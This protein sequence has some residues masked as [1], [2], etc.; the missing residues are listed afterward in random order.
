MT[1][2]REIGVCVRRRALCTAGVFLLA[3]FGLGGCLPVQE[4]KEAVRRDFLESALHQNALASLAYARSAQEVLALHPGWRDGTLATGT[5]DALGLGVPSGGAGTRFKA[6]YCRQTTPDADGKFR[7]V[8]TVWP[9]SVNPA[10]FELQG[11]GRNA[12]VLLSKEMA[13]L[14]GESAVG[15]MRAGAIMTAGWNEAIH[16]TLLP[17]ECDTLALPEGTPVLAMEISRQ[18]PGTRQATELGYTFR[19]CDVGEEG[20]RIKST[21]TN[22]DEEGTET[23]DPE[24]L[25]RDK[26]Y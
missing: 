14:M 26:C 5:F 22:T 23:P 25:F 12:G 4:Q 16:T 9:E 15:I 7:E 1:L 8:L 21:L 17:A 6:G 24:K 13:N 3:G 10:S 20:A 11:I 18:D 19:N 2:I